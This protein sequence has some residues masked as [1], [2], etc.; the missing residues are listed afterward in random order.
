MDKEIKAVAYIRV[1]K[2][3]QLEVESGIHK[4]LNAIQECCKQNGW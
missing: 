4:Q 1:N 2:I 3:E